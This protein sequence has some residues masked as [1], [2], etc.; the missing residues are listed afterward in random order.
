M[1]TQTQGFL[2]AGVMILLFTGCYTQFATLESKPEETDSVTVAAQNP[3]REREVCYWERNFFGRWEL[4]C[5]RTNYS[6]NWF[7]YYNRPWWYHNT[8]DD[9]DFNPYVCHCPYHLFYNSNCEMCWYYCDRWSSMHQHPH[10][11]PVNN[12]TVNTTVNNKPKK[13]G[14]VNGTGGRIPQTG[15]KIIVG[16]TPFTTGVIPVVDTATQ[17][18]PVENVNQNTNTTNNTNTGQTITPVTGDTNRIIPREP[19]GGGG[20]SGRGR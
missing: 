16:Q 18:H 6:N 9:P 12:N 5:Y 20:R 7:S 13:I 17:I 14:T 19:A 15:D 1:K 11:H 8:F 2:W 10:P 4:N 3:V